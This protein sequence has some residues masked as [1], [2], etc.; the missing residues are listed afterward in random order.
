V[1]V[2]AAKGGTVAL[3]ENLN[4]HPD[5]H[6]AFAPGELLPREKHFFDRHWDRGI[7]WYRA[8]FDRPGLIQ[9]EKTPSYLR[10]PICHQRM[11]QTI[12]EAKLICL[13]RNPVRRAHSAWNMVQQ[14]SPAH[15]EWASDE[16]RS[17]RGLS[18]EDAIEATPRLIDDGRYCDQIEGLL[19]FFPRERIF[20]GISERFRN[21]LDGQMAAL[22]GFLGVRPFAGEWREHHNRGYGSPLAEHTRRRLDSLFAP[23][24]ERLFALLGERIPEWDSAP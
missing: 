22:L 11:A 16:I 7:D 21:D 24:N 13:L 18:F 9:G 3:W 10:L 6:L 8:Q 5:L 19:R 2:G 14:L 20:V 1:I 23:E 4:L 15:L 12:P 17:M